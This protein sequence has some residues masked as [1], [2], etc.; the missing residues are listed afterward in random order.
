[1]VENQ[2]Q[3]TADQQHQAETF[4]QTQDIAATLAQRGNRYGAF[5]GHAKITQS[6]KRAMQDSPNWTSLTDQQREALEQAYDIGEQWRSEAEEY[7]QVKAAAEIRR[8]QREATESE[9]LQ[10]PVIQGP[11]RQSRRTK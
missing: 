11:N 3:M 9:Q 10:A 1:M 2:T 8:A 5:P 4:G 7:R 6:L